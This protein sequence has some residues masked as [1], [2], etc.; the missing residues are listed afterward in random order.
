[1]KAMRIEGRW[2]CNDRLPSRLFSCGHRLFEAHC[3][4]LNFTRVFFCVGVS[5]DFNTTPH[6][7][8]IF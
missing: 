4:F 2:L 7:R 6:F 8:A 1:M 3:P 5:L